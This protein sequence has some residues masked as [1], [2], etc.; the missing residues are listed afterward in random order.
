M[1]DFKEFDSVRSGLDADRETKK[2]REALLSQNSFHVLQYELRR[3]SLQAQSR[4]DDP[5][6]D[7]A[8]REIADID[9]EDALRIFKDM[10]MTGQ[11][12]PGLRLKGTRR[13]SFRPKTNP[14]HYPHFIGE[15]NGK[16]VRDDYSSAFDTS[17]IVPADG[18]LLLMQAVVVDFCFHQAEHHILLYAGLT[19]HH[20]F[21]G[22]ANPFRH[23]LCNKVMRNLRNK[24][25]QIAQA[26]RDNLIDASGHLLTTTMGELQSQI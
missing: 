18:D 26:D 22:Q 19:D 20:E 9:V 6:V 2:H 21:K 25:Q 10:V 7:I 17:I 5:K 3:Y 13:T 11:V 24:F 8:A 4:L 15:E 16:I 23:T 14:A 1:N 12:P